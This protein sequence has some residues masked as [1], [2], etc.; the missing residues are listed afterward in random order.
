MDHVKD[1]LSKFARNTRMSVSECG[2]LTKVAQKWL[3]LHVNVVPVEQVYS[4][5][6]SDYRVMRM[7]THS[8]PLHAYSN[9]NGDIDIPTFLFVTS[10]A[11]AVKTDTPGFE[12]FKDCVLPRPVGEEAW[13]ALERADQWKEVAY[14]LALNATKRPQFGALIES[15]YHYPKTAWLPT[16]NNEPH[17]IYDAMQKFNAD[18]LIASDIDDIISQIELSNDAL[19]ITPVT[20]NVVVK[21]EPIP[22]I[23][24][25][26]STISLTAPSSANTTLDGL[27]PS[28]EAYRRRAGLI[29]TFDTQKL[30]K[31][32][33]YATMGCTVHQI[34][35]NVLARYQDELM[36]ITDSV[37]RNVA[38]EALDAFTNVPAFD[39]NKSVRGKVFATILKKDQWEPREFLK[40]VVCAGQYMNERASTRYMDLG[41]QQELDSAMMTVIAALA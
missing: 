10:H 36:P 20:N 28:M 31:Q 21:V 37:E 27:R 9:Q 35:P 6:A 25:S 16:E 22:E 3:T 30:A 33:I 11:D 18:E 24:E 1:V 40:H 26:V 5:I 23:N 19:D 34:P 2:N 13:H 41:T 12:A 38:L 15:I 39:P 32:M 17:R 8:P 29:A 14:Y 4:S 7:R